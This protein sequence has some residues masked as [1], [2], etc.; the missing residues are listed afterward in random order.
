[1]SWW[2]SWTAFSLSWLWYSNVLL[3]QI[4]GED[5]AWKKTVFLGGCA[6]RKSPQHLLPDFPAAVAQ[7]PVFLRGLLPNLINCET[8]VGGMWQS[9][10]APRRV[11]QTYQRRHRH[12]RKPQITGWCPAFHKY[13]AVRRSA[14]QQKRGIY[15]M[16]Q[17]VK[18]NENKAERKEIQ[19]RLNCAVIAVG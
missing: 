9:S 15:R 2:K 4:Y 7:T 16:C 1:M 6:E 12:S 18:R 13:D 17:F 19:K 5:V 10:V 3:K 8:V 11:T 14:P